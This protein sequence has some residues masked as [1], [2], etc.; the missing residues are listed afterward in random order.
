[1]VYLLINKDNKYLISWASDKKR[2]MEEELDGLGFELLT[3]EWYNQSFFD[4]L[5]KLN[6]KGDIGADFSADRLTNIE[7]ELS[8][9]RTKLT[10]NEVKKAILL[11]EQYSRLLTDFCIYLKPHQTEKE[12][13]ENFNYCCSNNKINLPVLMI[14]SDDR[15]FSYRHLVA[16]DKK[17]DRYMLLATVAQRDGI[18]A[19]V[20]R[21]VYFGKTPQNIVKRQNAVNYMEA[22][23]WYHSKPGV[24]LKDIFNLGKDM[25]KKLGYKDEYKNHIQGGLVAYTSREIL[26]DDICDCFLEENNLLG[27]NPTVSGAKAED[28]VLVAINGIRQLSID[29]RWPYEDIKIENNKY[30]KPLILE[31]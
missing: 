2:I 29:E 22:F 26:A 27:W 12:V 9:L 30:Q 24:N 7:H 13:A 15:I 17:I 8:V 21:S 28:M 6:L 1:M 3:Y 16:T 5:D 19:S 10:E 4:A 20:T 25:Y 11:C 14:G 31:I 18:N 23:Y